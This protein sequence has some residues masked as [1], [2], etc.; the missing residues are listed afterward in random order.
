MNSERLFISFK[1]KVGCVPVMTILSLTSILFVNILV[2]EVNVFCFV[3]NCACVIPPL[4]FAIF[5]SMLSPPIFKLEQ[6][7][8]AQL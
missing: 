4:E 7:I 2:E 6:S 1:Y 3:S 8:V 5:V